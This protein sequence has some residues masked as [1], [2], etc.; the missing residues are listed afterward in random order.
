MTVSIESTSKST[1]GNGSVT[2]F[3]YDFKIFKNRDL[4]VIIRAANGT[5]TVLTQSNPTH[6]SVTHVGSDT[7]VVAVISNTGATP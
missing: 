4:T 6:Y 1:N 5:E 3:P 2:N 7:V